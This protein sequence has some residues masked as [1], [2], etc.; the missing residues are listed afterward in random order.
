M[1]K[2]LL[3]VYAAVSFACAD[4]GIGRFDRCMLSLSK[5]E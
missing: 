3:K 2:M 4:D 5:M 1:H